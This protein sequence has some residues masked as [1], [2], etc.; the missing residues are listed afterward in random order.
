MSSSGILI[1][2]FGMVFNASSVLKYL[3]FILA[4][5]NYMLI[6]HSSLIYIFKCS[7]FLIFNLLYVAI[8]VANELIY[9][10]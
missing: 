6:K 7:I 2:G 4:M 9:Y 1:G 3:T 5:L 10:A 8:I